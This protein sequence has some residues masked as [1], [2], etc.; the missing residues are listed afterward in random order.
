MRLYYGA[1]D[2]GMMDETS[3][4]ESDRLHELIADSL[5]E[6][7]GTVTGC[8]I[9]WS[10]EC[11][12]Q[13]SRNATDMVATYNGLFC[14]EEKCSEGRYCFPDGVLLINN[15]IKLV[16]EIET[17]KSG[18]LPVHLFGKWCASA[19]SRYFI[20]DRKSYR[21]IPFHRQAAFVQ[22]CDP[23]S[24]QG[25]TRTSKPEQWRKIENSVRAILPLP[26]SRITQYTLLWGDTYDF[27]YHGEKRQLLLGTVREGLGLA[28]DDV[29][30][31]IL[32]GDS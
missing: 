8:E 9:F 10:P 11:C 21:P 17:S 20:H 32:R 26:G 19:M 5:N 22:I 7:F 2:M 18:L 14:S 30:P 28:R 27:G 1:E 4:N 24:L 15:E 12:S 6:E 25:Q 16:I 23:T 13:A 3:Y 31:V 29:N